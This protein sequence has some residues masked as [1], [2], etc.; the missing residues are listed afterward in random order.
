V[1][2]NKRKGEFGGRVKRKMIKITVCL[3][4]LEMPEWKN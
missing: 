4:D 3:Y 2:K 1:T